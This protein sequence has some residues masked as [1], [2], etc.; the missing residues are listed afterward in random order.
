MAHSPRYTKET[1]D[2]AIRT[3]LANGA[4][5]TEVMQYLRDALEEMM[6]PKPAV[7]PYRSK[8]DHF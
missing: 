3:C 7:K 4:S 6:R 2:L 8:S 5:V 1:L